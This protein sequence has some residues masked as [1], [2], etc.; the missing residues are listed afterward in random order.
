[1]HIHFTLTILA[2][3]LVIGCDQPPH[4]G[5]QGYHC[6]NWPAGSLCDEGLRCINDVCTPCGT[7]D[8]MM[9]CDEIGHEYCLN[10]LAC[11]GGN[12]GFD[13]ETGQCNG[14][15]G[16]IGLPCCGDATCPNGGT[17]GDNGICEGDIDEQCQGGS[18]PFDITLIDKGCGA[19]TTTVWVDTPEEAEA[20]R[21]LVVAAAVPGEE[22]CDLDEAPAF[23]DVCLTDQYGTGGYQLWNCSPE[24]LA[25][26]EQY[27][28]SS[29][30]CIWADG[31]C[32]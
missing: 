28:C 2:T 13:G 30:D 22:V 19:L 29:A 14:D 31:A 23:T 9:C 32:P 18:T 17:C 10:G 21:Q 8:G 24:Q 11:E 5:E 12:Q 27:Y 20:C 4:A 15:C 3:L 25:A 16:S 7:Q 26:C 6:A 1:M